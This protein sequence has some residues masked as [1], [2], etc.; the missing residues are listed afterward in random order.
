MCCNFSNLLG[1]DCGGLTVPDFIVGSNHD[2]CN[3]I[4]GMNTGSCG[5]SGSVGGSNTNTCSCCNN[6]PCR[7]C[8]DG[9]Q[10]NCCTGTVGG[11]NTESCER[12]DACEREE[13]CGC[14]NNGIV[15]GIVASTSCHRCGRRRG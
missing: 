2:S 14:R 5:C 10:N 1:C 4:G 8:C 6:C 12:E 15:G 3:I 11:T 13:E 9:C 7:F